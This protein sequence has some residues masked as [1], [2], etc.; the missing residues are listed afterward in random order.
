MTHSAVRSQGKKI[1]ACFLLS[2]Q[3]LYTK[4]QLALLLSCSFMRLKKKKK[5][6]IV[7]EDGKEGGRGRERGREKEGKGTNGREGEG[8]EGREEGREGGER[9]EKRKEKQLHPLG[10]RDRFL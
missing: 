4:R 7:R 5:G 6:K 2:V 9:E 1:S 3:V 10:V 8:E